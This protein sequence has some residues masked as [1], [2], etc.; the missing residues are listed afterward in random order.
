ME[1]VSDDS[2]GIYHFETNSGNR[3]HSGCHYSFKPK[4]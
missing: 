2:R 3:I 1:F 4:A